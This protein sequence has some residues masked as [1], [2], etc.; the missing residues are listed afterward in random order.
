MGNFE[1]QPAAQKAVCLGTPKFVAGVW[2]EG[3]LVEDC[4]LNRGGLA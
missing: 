2:S 4:A 3:S 1:L